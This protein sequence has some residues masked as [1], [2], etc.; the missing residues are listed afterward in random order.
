[1]NIPIILEKANQNMIGIDLASKLLQSRIILLEGPI[2]DEFA[3]IIIS[4]LLYLKAIDK[5]PITIQIMS[6]G[7]SAYAGLGIYDIIQTVKK[8]HIVKT[9]GMGL[10]ASMG[11]LLLSSGSEGERKVYDNTT[12][13]IH[14]P[15][16]G[17]IGTIAELKINYDE[18]QRLKD[19]LF[20]I[21][22]KHGASTEIKDLME[23]DTWLTPEDAIKLG[24]I[25]GIK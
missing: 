23:K 12:I 25:D 24:L 15:S 22:I 20:D 8:T 5:T 7:G 10:C 1:M 3:G 4:Q 18:G 17:A 2:D 9:I 13:M 21:Y 11:S 6:P 16:G 19:K 14:Q